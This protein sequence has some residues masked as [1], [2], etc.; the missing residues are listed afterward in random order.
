MSRENTSATTGIGLTR[1]QFTRLA[2]S[3]G[4]LA[5]ASA[6]PGCDLR[7][8]SQGVTSDEVTASRPSDA[9]DEVVCRASLSNPASIEPHGVYEASGMQVCRLLFEPLLAC[10]CLSGEV[11]PAAATSYELLSDGLTYRFM[12]AENAV[13]T[14]GETVTASNF[15]TA[16]ESLVQP[17][18]GV[19]GASPHASLLSN[20]T[21]YRDFITGTAAEITG[22]RASGDFT[23]EVS[24]DTPDPDFPTIV[25][26][27]AL[28]P[29]PTTVTELTTFSSSP[30]GNGPFMMDGSWVDQQYI[31]L[32]RSETFHGPAPQLTAVRFTIFKDDATAFSEFQAG[33]L[34]VSPVPLSEFA[35]LS[36]TITPAPDGY[37]LTADTPGIDGMLDAVC[38]LAFNFTDG[39]LSSLELR[40]AISLAIDR[41]AICN[42][43]YAGIYHAADGIIPA[44]M[45]EYVEGSWPDCTYDVRAAA[46]ALVAAGFP[47]GDGAPTITISFGSTEQSTQVT[48][49]I[50]NNLASIGLAVELDESQWSDYET[51]IHDGR[52]QIMVGSWVSDAR[53]SD[54]VL[55]PLFQSTS[56]YNYGGFSLPLFDDGLVQAR[57]LTDEAERLE[58]YRELDALL[59]TMIPAVPLFYYTL[60]HVCSADVVTL[61][62]DPCG[63]F[64]F[65]Q[66][67]MTASAETSG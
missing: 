5:A 4:M 36:S 58:A 53:K 63:F 2:V 12:L 46:Q 18:D 39:D 31:R 14:N 60:H 52:F 64:D 15:K 33:N 17:V 20:V 67:E 51:Q 10:D 19:A 34:D 6:L 48:Q 7:A 40:R 47:G 38:Y 55:R 57:Q 3:A 32:V 24:L 45:D 30:V 42:E 41:E 27:P 11:V 9:V 56:S 1:R 43:V 26:H 59:G 21:G 28:S 54:A 29:I 13:F 23:L 61:A 8:E 35:S 25:C 65:A 62:A 44:N 49:M 16:W 37:T 22:I 50:A 66:A